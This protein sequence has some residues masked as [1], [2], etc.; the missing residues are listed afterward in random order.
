MF[1][2]CFDYFDVC[3]DCYTELVA[4]SLG[5]W[6]F[7]GTFSHC[8]ERYSRRDAAG[9]DLVPAT[10]G[11]R[12]RG[13]GNGIDESFEYEL[14]FEWEGTSEPP[15]VP[16][17]PSPLGSSQE[18]R[19]WPVTMHPGLEGLRKLRGLVERE[20]ACA[21]PGC[22]FKFDTFVPILQRAMSRGYVEDRYG[23]LQERADLMI[24]HRLK[25]LLGYRV[26]QR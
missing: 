6:Y 5:R 20:N 16:L 10:R 15:S 26:Q 23:P 24:H 11:L 22:T 21:L 7:S 18:M 14:K 19:P 3:L 17:P 2:L 1:S 12:L 13:G 4:T 9:L 8:A 25:C